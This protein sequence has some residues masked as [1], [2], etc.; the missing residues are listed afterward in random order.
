MPEIPLQVQH[1][2]FSPNKISFGLGTA[3]NVGQECRLLGGTR[4]LVVTDPGIVKAGLLEPVRD[5]FKTAGVAEVLFDRVEP[6]PPS[7]VVDEGA[8]SGRA[9]KCK[10]V[11]GIGGGSSLDVA[12]GISAMMTNEGSIL[13]V[14]GPERISKP[15]V[16]LILI[17]TT[18]GTGSEATRALVV[19]DYTDPKMT[20]KNTALSS[21]L[22][23]DVAIVDPL[24]TVT[25]PP[26]ITADTGIDAL[27]HAIEAYVSVNATPFSDI[28]AEKAIAWIGQYLPIAWAKGSNLEARYFLS[29]SS[30]FAGMAFASGGLG[31]VHALAHTLG[32]EYHL[33]HGPSIEAILLAVMKYNLS[34]NPQKY[35]RIA[36]LLGKNTA[37]LSD[38]KASEAAVEAVRELLENMRIPYRLGDYGVSK[39]DIPKLVQSTMRESRFFALNPRDIK[40]EDLRSIYEEAF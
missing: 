31:A 7:R 34:G 5:S 18:S 29:L 1:N 30:T 8:A 11:V 4:I 38:L 33:A 17:P 32:A 21:F 27:A 24:L 2:F 10:M 12:K 37:G 26:R 15:G 6:E 20:R 22:L 9:E 40:E 36:A 35:A 3:R 25:V 23:P 39:T 28:L 19:T 13:D 14:C 16:P